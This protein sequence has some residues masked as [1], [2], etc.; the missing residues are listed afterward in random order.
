[1]VQLFSD[2][3]S[4][5][6][7]GLIDSGIGGF[8]VLRE[9]QKQMP[10]ENIV[11]LGDAMRM[12]Y[13]ER[14]NDEIIAFG[15]SDIRFLE[16][17]GVKAILLAC[18]TL[19]S[20]VDCLQAEVPL[21]SIVEAGCQATVEKQKTGP[22]G[23]IATTATVK[24]GAYEKTLKQYSESVYYITQGT[25]TLAK[26]INNHPNELLLLRKHIKE[27]I[28]P[29]LKKE[30][31]NALLLGCTHFPIVRKT[32]EEM[33]P[34]LS[35]ID[36]ARKQI[37]LLKNFLQDNQILNT[38]ITD[39][40]TEICATGTTSDFIIFEDMVD[41]LALACNDLEQVQLDID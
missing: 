20:L 35:I 7:I 8:T 12:P 30:K 34:R 37:A 41:Q 16:K 9:L 3:N 25:R 13:G 33:Y 14:E 31:V 6:P 32:I 17:K 24:N 15:N 19:S 36:P 2:T 5:R 28:D 21:F 11:Y 23:L 27:A 10:R 38:S 40:K 39:G 29:I 4:K 22:V 1:M 26:V 18:N